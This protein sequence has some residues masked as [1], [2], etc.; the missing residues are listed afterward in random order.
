MTESASSPPARAKKKLTKDDLEAMTTD[1]LFALVRNEATPRETREAGAVILLQQ[2]EQPAYKKS[3]IGE[4]AARYSLTPAP[5]MIDD[6]SMIHAK[7]QPIGGSPHLTHAAPMP[8]ATVPVYRQEEWAAKFND[9]SRALAEAM[10]QIHGRCDDLVLK[11]VVLSTEIG[12]ARAELGQ[13]TG[14]LEAM[15]QKLCKLEG[16]WIL[17]VLAWLHSLFS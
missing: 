1:T 11:S 10:D 16:L 4:V 17:R 3:V 12:A 14:E 8:A 9:V 2:R 6:G 13:A 7:G 5:T 15:K